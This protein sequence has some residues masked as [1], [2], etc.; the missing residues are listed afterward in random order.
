MERPRRV[1]MPGQPHH[2]ELPARPGALAFRHHADRRAFLRD[3]RHLAKTHGVTVLAYCLLPDRAC[4]VAA[5]GDVSALGALTV[6]LTEIGRQRRGEA[7]WEAFS[8]WCPLDEDAMWAAIRCVERAPV[9]AGLAACAEDYRWSSAGAR[10]GLRTDPLAAAH[11]LIA[12]GPADW[13]GFLAQDHRDRSAEI[14]WATTLCRPCGS[15]GF[16]ELLELLLGCAFPKL[17]AEFAAVDAA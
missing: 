8:P 17:P 10:C 6:A 15:A 13:R 2:I 1:V 4:L 9:E 5:P 11:E 14:R 12:A 3:L 7:V 16:V